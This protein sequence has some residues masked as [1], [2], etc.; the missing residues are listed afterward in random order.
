MGF[1]DKVGDVLSNTGREI[2]ASAKNVAD[3][4]NLNSQIRAQQTL[5]QSLY[6][7][8][9]EKYYEE[10]KDDSTCKYADKVA[11]ITDAKNKIVTFQHEIDRIKGRQICPTCGA[12][13][14]PDVV[15]CP[16]CGTNLAAV[17]TQNQ[18]PAS[19]PATAFCPNC[20]APLEAGSTFCMNC[21]T[22]I[23]NAAAPAATPAA[24]AAAP[25]YSAPQE[26][27]PG[28]SAVGETAGSAAPTEADS[29]PAEPVETDAIPSESVETDS[30]SS[31]PVT[32]EETISSDA[33]ASPAAGSVPDSGWFCTNCGAKNEPG[34]MFCYRCGTKKA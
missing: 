19:A 12:S 34:T 11:S 33:A 2:S 24:D 28:E 29:M 21:G 17:R 30:V 20:G 14:E 27:V 5:I 1:F 13:V 31:E 10:S 7:E 8:L 16:S 3:T 4:S 23:D 22:K 26:A 15:F 9:G 25:E 18:Q 32:A 6:K